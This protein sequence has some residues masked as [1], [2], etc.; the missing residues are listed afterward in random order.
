MTKFE[1][2][3]IMIKPDGVAR[4]LIAEVISRFE[5]KG[6][7]LMAIKMAKAT[8]S[9]LTEH[10]AHL[11][12]EK[13]FPQIL[14]SMTAGPLVCMVWAGH[15]AVSVCRDLIGATDPCKAAIGTIRGDLALEVG[16]NVV[17]GSD[18][19]ENAEREIN[20][21][22]GEEAGAILDEDRLFKAYYPNN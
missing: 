16:A 22:F 12:K 13:F 7:K 18:S 11:V 9:I 21:W 2:S 3:Y 10:Y 20:I 4:G 19:V 5:K 1:Q 6:L 8:E 14:S 17:H 15:N